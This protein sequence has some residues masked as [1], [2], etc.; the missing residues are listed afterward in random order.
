MGDL[1]C[2]EVCE[3]TLQTVP[4]PAP[5]VLAGMPLV[6]TLDLGLKLLALHDDK[7]DLGAF[8]E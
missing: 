2:F 7:I 8:D 6:D 1:L 3:L 4:E 5:A